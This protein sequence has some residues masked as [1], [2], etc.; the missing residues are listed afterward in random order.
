MWGKSIGPCYFC[1]QV[2]IYIQ[3]V[4][5]CLLNAHLV[6]FKTISASTLTQG[7]ISGGTECVNTN[8]DDLS[9]S[10]TSALHQTIN[11]VSQLVIDCLRN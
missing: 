10:Y 5:S 6:Q 2:F 3:R 4:G 1:S 8:I 7:W 9:Y 11:H